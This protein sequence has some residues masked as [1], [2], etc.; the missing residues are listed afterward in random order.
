MWSIFPAAMASRRRGRLIFI[1]RLRV[2]RSKIGGESVM[3]TSI[4]L[5]KAEARRPDAKRIFAVTRWLA[6]LLLLFSLAAPALAAE[7]RSTARSAPPAQAQAQAD[8][9]PAEAPA[10]NAPPSERLDA[11]KA[12]LDKITAALA[13]ENVA[14]PDLLKWR[15]EIDPILNQVLGVAAEVAPK[16]AATKL[17]LEQLGPPPDKDAADQAPEDPKIAQDRKEQLKQQASFDD[18]AKR[19]KLLQVQAE[20]LAAQIGERRRALFTSSVFQASQSI[21][22]PALWVDVAQEAPRDFA[23]TRAVFAELLRQLQYNVTG[24]KAAMAAGLLALIVFSAAWAVVAIL[25]LLPKA[26][27]QRELNALRL[28]VAALWS[29]LAVMVPPLGA[30]GALFAL[31]NWLGVS[32]PQLQ[33]LGFTMVGLAA[34]LAVTAG[35]ITAVLAPYRG[36]W[37][38]IDLSDRVARRLSRLILTLMGVA[39]VGRI[40]EV[41]AETVGASLQ[42]SVAARGLFAL[43]VGLI[44]ARGLYGIIMSP[45]AKGEDGARPANIVDESPFWAP[46]RLL[47]WLAT[48]AILGAAVSGYVALSAFLVNQMAWM[49]FVGALLFLLLKL[50]DGALE[51]AFRPTSRMSRSLTATIGVGRE[52]LQQIGVLLSGLITVALAA[53]AVML[54]LAPWGI[55]S[56]DMIG[57]AQSLF[58]GVK[59]GDM[60]ISL[61]SVVLALVFFAVGYGLTGAVRNWLENRYLPLTQLDQGLRDA[62]SASVGYLGVGLSLG[63]A[64]SYVG[65]SLEKLALVAGALSVGIGLGLQGVVANFVSGLIIMWERAIRVGDLVVVGGETGTVRRINIRATEIQTADRATTIVP[66]GNMITG[67][68][69]NFVR[70]DR[71]GRV[72]IPVQANWDADPEKV[73]QLLV[74]TAR[75]HDEV[76]GFPAPFAL[77]VRFG[78]MLEFEL[79]CFVEDV[80]RAARVRSDLHFAIF[81]AF[82]EA[83]LKMTPPASSVPL[84]V[85]ALEPYLRALAPPAFSRAAVQDIVKDTKN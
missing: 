62:I 37:R 70:L 39:C 17:R 60:S 14:D 32:D 34:R 1:A 27:P 15:G 33:N 31:V 21:V 8:D 4:R 2:G 19:A 72:V 13:A 20:Q 12:G 63:L 46:I 40:I 61:W 51:Q 49:A 25:R 59:L 48:F 3:I 18:L 77:F 84:D 11:A 35:M 5:G 26:K 58:F 53:A 52:S 28:S 44:L 68:V 79:Y 10:A 45:D 23:S 43:L 22:A 41:L 56:H 9:A 67:V 76:V 30:L 85:A 75:A 74:D 57:A 6:A 54:V 29:G 78:P 82:A 66:N 7:P 81:R 55:Q 24:S 42:V 65:F 47:T 71:V 83:G 16:Q 69:K 73:R 38:P 50:S 36:F 64:L 80:D